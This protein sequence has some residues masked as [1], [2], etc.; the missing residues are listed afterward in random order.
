[1]VTHLELSFLASVAL[2]YILFQARPAGLTRSCWFG[3]LNLGA[4][5]AIFGTRVAVA[6]VATSCSIWVVLR[7]MLLLQPRKTLVAQVWLV[8]TYLTIAT[9]FLYYKCLFELDGINIP[10]W[11]DATMPFDLQLLS[12][13]QSLAVAYLTLRLIDMTRA[14]AAGTELLDPVSTAGYLLP[15]FMTPAGPTNVY[16][17]HV[18]MNDVPQPAPNWSQFLDS[19]NLITSGMVLKFV[20]AEGLRLIVVG[21]VGNWPSETLADSALIFLYIY[22]EFAGYSL[23]ALGVGRLLAVPTPVNF[24]APYRAQ[25]L[26]E[27]WTRWHISLGDFVKRNLYFPIQIAL[28]RRYGRAWAYW[29]NLLALSLPFVLVGLWHRLTWGFLI[30][31]I[32]IGC[33][34]TLEKVF[35][36]TLARFGERHPAAARLWTVLGPIYAVGTIIGTLHFVMP[37]ML[38]TH[39]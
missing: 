9:G 20:L 24:R 34:V 8:A 27:F 1:M 33:M 18:R 19:G 17:D 29:T 16:V 3:L 31:G 15:F 13:V 35:Q 26:T 21:A 10:P 30:W 7:F 36:P 12:I 5:S 28:V 14:V 2:A 6:L 23:V 22:L 11:S 4:I 38:G 25:S 37:A 32:A 39:K